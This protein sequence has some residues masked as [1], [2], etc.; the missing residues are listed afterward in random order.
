MLGREPI[1]TP[2]GGFLVDGRGRRSYVTSAGS[3][4]SI[5]KHVLMS[6]L[7]PAYAVEGTKL[8]VEYFGERYP[9][10]VAVVGSS[11]IFD[12]EN[13]RIRA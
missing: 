13:A 3:A 9:V 8:A 2:D 4:P 1:T 6:Y 11:P 7:P 5:G 10:T 12:P